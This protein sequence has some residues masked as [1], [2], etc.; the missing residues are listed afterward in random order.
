LGCKWTILLM[1]QIAEGINRPGK[2]VKVADGLTTKV[3]NQCLNCMINYGIL[4]KKSFV[5]IPPKVEY[6]LTPF[7]ADLL[8]LLKEIKLL[9]NK[10]FGN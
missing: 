1:E 4:E 9:Q 10:Y 2:L 3:L 7:G 5:E 8:Q 6:Y